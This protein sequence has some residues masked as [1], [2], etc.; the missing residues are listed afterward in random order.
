MLNLEYKRWEFTLEVYGNI[1]IY[2]NVMQNGGPWFWWWFSKN[3]NQ[4]S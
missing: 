3:E 1:K 2:K 4:L